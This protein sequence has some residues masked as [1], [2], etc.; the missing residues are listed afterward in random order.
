M[1]KRLWQ[2]H[3]WL[4]LFAG[5]GLLVIGLSGSL[6][7]FREELESLF[8]PSLARVEPTPAGRLSLDALLQNAQRQLP[9]HEITGWLVQY[10][11]PRS[12]DVLYVIQRGHNEWL[13]ATLDQYTGRLL[14]SPRLGTTTFT[15]WMLDLHYTF[16]A[17]NVGLVI[18]AL[19][20]VALCL[21][22]ITGVWI[23][24]EFWKH[25]FTLRWKRGARILFSDLHKFVGI[26]SAAFNLVLG[27]TGAY[28]NIAHVVGHMIY[29]DPPQA[30]ISERLY[31][32]SLSLD[33]LTADAAQRLP[34]YRANFI[35]LPSDPK[36][37]TI[38]F[39]GAFEPRGVMRGP[40]SSTVG[41]DAKTL[42]HQSSV[43]VRA[44]GVWA[45]I[46]DAFTPLHFGTF[47]GFFVKILWCVGG[48]TPGIL[49]VTGFLI[50]RSRRKS[51]AST[52]S[53]RPAPLPTPVGV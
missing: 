49:G 13:L 25:I 15:G 45:Q 37:P 17:D 40:Y 10:D 48:L 39:Y 35:S 33:A 38:T 19:L 42:A 7:V 2:I 47:G 51:R 43:D 26:T 4:G 14:A 16:F 5:L 44:S 36:T 9:D 18:V 27:F 28:W 8:N 24:R 31:S 6:L 1:R 11:S 29:G 52:S 53:K 12:A 32:D 50:W 34:G 23:Y 30:T 20:G 41:Y 46:Y 22:G 21:L 3:S